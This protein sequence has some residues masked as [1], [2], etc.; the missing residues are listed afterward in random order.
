[1][2]LNA[3]TIASRIDG[4]TAAEIA[5]SIA[6]A[7]RAGEFAAGSTLPTIRGLANALHTSP[8]T[9][10]DAWRTLRHHGLIE[11]DRR[12]GTTVRADWPFGSERWWHV[13]VASGT[14][15]LDLSTGTPDPTL[16]PDLGAALARVRLD[17]QVTSYL[18]RPLLP[19]LEEELRSRWP[20]D[21]AAITM[22]D[23]AQDALDRIITLTIGLGDR[24]VVETPT[25]PPLL[26]MLE[27]AGAEI[28]GVPVDAQGLDP[29]GLAAALAEPIR[30]IFLQPRAHNPTGA[31]ITTARAATIAELLEPTATLIVEDDHSGDVAGV[32]LVSLGQ[33]LPDRTIHIHSF[34]KSHGPDLRLAAV[35]GA[36][37]P[38]SAIVRR[39]QLGPSWTSRL[40]QQVLLALLTDRDAQVAV[41]TAAELYLERRRALGAALEQRGLRINPLGT[42]LNLWVP[43]ADEQSTVVALAALGVGVAPGR[44]FEVTPSVI[45]HVRVTVSTL[46]EPT[47][48]ADAIV[49]AAS[50]D[51]GYASTSAR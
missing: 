31:A 48:L 6:Q 40:L 39:R 29:D 50:T 43:V 4:R 17:H 27:L 5:T 42:G 36:A 11:T 23:G 24:V 46:D 49:A 18:D 28:I 30:A 32:P 37:G 1:M 2:T 13:P 3:H 33:W 34:S 8:S 15:E 44:P 14:L 35:G 7:I 51:A 20:F 16:L 45:G 26:D 41:A 19:A 25:F 9:V 47:Q 21:A 10:S 38:I 22:L 12:R